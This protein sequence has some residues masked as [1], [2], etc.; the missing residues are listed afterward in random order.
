MSKGHTFK[1]K[2]EGKFTRL[3]KTGAHWLASKLKARGQVLVTRSCEELLDFHMS[4]TS[5]QFNTEFRVWFPLA[6]RDELMST[7]WAKFFN[8]PADDFAFVRKE[9]ALTVLTDVKLAV[10]AALNNLFSRR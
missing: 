8:R 5:T 3:E 6:T 10:V 2:F 9:D 4:G 1:L 7:R